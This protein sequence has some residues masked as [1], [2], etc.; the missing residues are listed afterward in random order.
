MRRGIPESGPGRAGPASESTG[1]VSGTRAGA[2][3]GT[4]GQAVGTR[5]RK[6][7]AALQR[8][9]SSPEGAQ[10]RN[11]AARRAAAVGSVM[12]HGGSCGDPGL[13]SA[14]KQQ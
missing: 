12:H 4:T 6:L 8:H 2:V 13:L 7:C 5:G 3:G 1:R 14:T 10:G 11:G 9:T